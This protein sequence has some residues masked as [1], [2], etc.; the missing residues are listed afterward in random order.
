[1]AQAPDFRGGYV[2]EPTAPGGGGYD[3]FAPQNYSGPVAP[4]YRGG[5]AG[6][7]IVPGGG[8][9]D[10]GRDIG[11]GTVPTKP[12]GTPINPNAVP[13]NVATGAAAVTTSNIPT[14]PFG[15]TESAT[16]V[17]SILTSKTS[18]STAAG[19]VIG[20]YTL[21]NV[22]PN[23]LE[24]F[25]S[26]APLWTLAVLTK[27]QFN[28]PSSYR[29]STA[30]LKHIVFASGGRF[31]DQRQG[32]IYG[33]PEYYINNFVMT[34]AIAPGPK[35]G[36]T[37]GF[38]F[39]FDIYE[40]FS[41]GLLL[42]S[43]QASAIN[44]GYANYIDNAP[45]V[46]RLDLQGYDDEGRIVESVKP[47]FFVLRL[48]SVKFQVDESGSTYKVEAVAYN[49][50]GFS[51]VIDTTYKDLTLIPGAKGTVEEILNSGE[52]SLAAALNKVEEDLVRNKRIKI[53]D[54]YIIS[55]PEKSSDFNRVVGA[56]QVT[57]NRATANP[58]AAPT[59][60]I[61]GT[62]TPV[63]TDFNINPIGS[64]DFGFD[65]GT[66]GNFPFA[67]E[68]AVVDPN[69]GIV[70]R[71]QMIID[72]KKR[73]FQF[74]QG[75]KITHMINQIVL[76]STYAKK[77]MDPN[78]I[79]NGFIKWWRIDVQIELL[80][81]DDLV[82][83]YA[84]RYTFRVVPFL[85]HQTIFSNVNSA[86]IAYDSIAKEICKRYDYIYT[87][88][89]TD[90]LK[91]DIQINT[92]FFR[93]IDPGI[94]GNSALNSD[95]NQA[96]AVEQ[97]NK[98]TSK[99]EGLTPAA[100]LTNTGRARPIR[101]PENLSAYSGGAGTA[102]NTEQRVAES[103]H[104]A[105]TQ[106]TGD[107]ISV[108]LEILGDTYWMVESGMGNYFSPTGQSTQ[109]T[110]DGSVNYEAGDVFVF[111]TFNTPADVNT[112]TGLYDFQTG[113]SSKTSPFGGI[114]RVTKCES[115][116]VDG[117]FKQKLR[118]L[119]MPTQITDINDGSGP[120][121]P[122]VPDKASSP[123]IVIGPDGTPNTSL[124]AYPNYNTTGRS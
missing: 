63:Q 57:T 3:P 74:S 120:P 92:L 80:E 90:V 29:N 107:L 33:T 95:P 59:Q 31:D 71:D 81:Y 26:F 97:T 49:H 104:K 43:L 115:H 75:Q 30:D 10:P 6:D 7:Q 13:T 37:N 69:T 61:T 20:G 15:T 102:S 109:I 50:G 1:M 64:S 56:E 116:F 119:R 35:T 47:K 23:P 9:F 79:V 68:K 48:K 72:P 99:G 105:I 41:M 76:S 106:G 51:D 46:L 122:I 58:N 83:D 86:P 88:Q 93:G 78:N 55:F 87:G 16:I 18:P 22:R 32:T 36:N 38:K 62:T 24:K 5:F 40:P 96:G 85:V 121:A 82:G 91:F 124:S 25:A 54:E 77:A 52:Q 14:S 101:N 8:G 118:C 108:D 117:M 34:A 27:E 42:Q 19:V 21:S 12:D 110:D 94:E 2:G 84:R 111:L 70:V 113:A 114:Y 39:D 53:K 17:P 4:D 66:G 65:Q 73:T 100:Q 89:N 98:T 11:A 45:Y 60:V 28:N 123:A 67:D 112:D 44:A 103:F